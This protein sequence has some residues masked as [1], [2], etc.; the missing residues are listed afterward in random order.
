MVSKRQIIVY[1]NNFWDNLSSSKMCYC[2]RPM[3]LCIPIAIN[4]SPCVCCHA[5]QNHNPTLFTM[6]TLANYILQAILYNVYFLPGTVKTKNYREHFS[7]KNVSHDQDVKAQ[8]G[9]W[10]CR[11]A[12]LRHWQFC[13]SCLGGQAQTIMLVRRPDEEVL[14]WR[15]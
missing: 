8:W 10:A 2:D 4:K 3:Y 11:W 13:I 14:G 9:W 1:R 12:S 6:L 7:S 5:C 15:C